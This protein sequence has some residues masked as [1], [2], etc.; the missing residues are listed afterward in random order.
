M[1]LRPARTSPKIKTSTL[2]DFSGGLNVLDDDLN[3]ASKY[4]V[5]SD[6]I[7]YDID[8]AF[9]VRYGT[10]LFTDAA[11]A[12]SAPARLINAMYYNNNIICVFSSGEIVRV[13]GV[14]AVSVM[15]NAAVAA[16]LPDSPAAWGI[17]ESASFAQ[18]NGELIIANGS[19]KPLIVHQNLSIEYLH[20]VA[21]GS[22]INVPIARYVVVCNRFL[23]MVGDPVYP[24]RVHISSRD[25]SGTWY[26]DAPPNNGT[27]VDIG[28]IIPDGNII[29]GAVPFRDKLIITYAE[30]SIIGQLGVFSEDGETHTPDFSDG[31][32]E[33]GA[34]SH[35]VLASYG[36]DILMLDGVGVSSLKRTVFT[37]TIRPERVSDLVD[38]EMTKMLDALDFGSLEDR[39]FSVYDPRSG[40]F[41]FFIPNADTIGETTETKAFVFTF[42]P[43]LNVTSWQTHSGWN[44]TCAL[45]SSQGNIFFGDASGKLYLMGSKEN[46]IDHDFE[47]NISINNGD[48][49]PIMFDWE[50]PWVDFNKR[51][52]TKSSKYISFDA[53]GTARF[54]CRM[55]ADRYR[56]DVNLQEVP[57]LQLDFV[58]GDTGGYG[59]GPQPYGGGLNTNNQQLIAW[60]CKFELAKLHIDGQAAGGLRF[61]SVS[62]SYHDGSIFR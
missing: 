14:G 50:M 17:T 18:F 26:G 39:T 40:K 38:P 55:F 51:V 44:W 62:I 15:W 32:P 41:Y 58:A 45:R 25:T 2:R 27:F 20:D 59:H 53:R 8:G 60:P 33:Y 61:V 48:G 5:I 46:P 37:G 12:L 3:L 21:T 42:R 4:A 34:V 19:D 6:N 29:R 43:S 47:G 16:L 30:G 11:I 52:R 10:R 56:Y 22:N 54:T 31:V 35:R 7:G 36:D 24:N 23:V 9:A 28:S 57:E 13:D 49:L 1:A